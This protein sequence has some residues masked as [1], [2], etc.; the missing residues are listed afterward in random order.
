MTD[1]RLLLIRFKVHTVLN[2][3]TQFILK[4]GNFVRLSKWIADHQKLKYNDY[5]SPEGKYMDRYNLYR[6]I[7]D[8]EINDQPVNYLEFGVGDGETLNWWANCLKNKTFFKAVTFDD[9]YNGAVPN[10]MMMRVTMNTTV[11][12]LTRLRNIRAAA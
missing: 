10:K 8:N 7:L 9:P 12:K 2:P 1:F 3:L 5:F 11:M 6:H 4:T